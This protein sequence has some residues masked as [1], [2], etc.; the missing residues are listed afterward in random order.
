MISSVL[1]DVMSETEPDAEMKYLYQKYF[2]DS[3]QQLENIATDLFASTFQEALP[4]IN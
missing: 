2:D 1:D 4:L 3:K